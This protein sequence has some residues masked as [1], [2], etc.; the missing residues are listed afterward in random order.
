MLFTVYIHAS[1]HRQC[2]FRLRRLRCGA[3]CILVHGVTFRDRCKGSEL[4]YFEMQSSLAQHF[5]HGGDRRRAQIS[6]Q[7]QES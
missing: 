7:V 2:A 4:F 3:V 6:S 1:R 5:G